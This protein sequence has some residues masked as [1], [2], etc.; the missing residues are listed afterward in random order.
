MPKTVDLQEI[1]RNNPDIDLHELD[2]WRQLRRTL[3]E[4]GLHGRSR[5]RTAAFQGRRAQLV[6]D[7]ADN[8]PRLIRLQHI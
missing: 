6:D 8:D 5:T 2:S 7:D 1:A 3:I 4:N